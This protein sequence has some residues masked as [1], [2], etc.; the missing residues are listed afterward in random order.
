MLKKYLEDKR[1]DIYY[2]KTER[3]IKIIKFLDKIIKS[4]HPTFYLPGPY[5]KII[6]HGIQEKA[7]SLKRYLRYEHTLPDGE[8]IAL[9]F[10]P[11]N[12]STLQKDIPTVVLF[13]GV[14]GDSVASYSVELANQVYS[15][16]GWRLCVV[17][18]RGYG[19]MPYRG[20][21]I[22][23]FGRHY[24]THDILQALQRNYPESNLYLIGVSMGAL[25]I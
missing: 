1:M 12:H 6:F 9:D 24:E 4:Y 11:K 15:K 3:N 5:P 8:I 25:D 14:F 17:H 21:H 20:D 22:F 18:R 16:L 13:P 19:G 10:F 23:S 7:I 2:K